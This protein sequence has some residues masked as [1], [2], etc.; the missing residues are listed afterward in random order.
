MGPLVVLLICTSGDASLRFQSQDGHPHFGSLSLV[1][2]G[3][4]RFISGVTS[5]DRL[6]FFQDKIPNDTEALL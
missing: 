2:N 5:A 1:Y 6:D 3:F 4:L